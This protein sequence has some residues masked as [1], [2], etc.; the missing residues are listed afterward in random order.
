LAYSGWRHSV[1]RFDA[2]N[3]AAGGKGPGL[4]RAIVVVALALVGCGAAP[5]RPPAVAADRPASP[6]NRAQLVPAA[7][8]AATGAANAPPL[9]MAEPALPDPART[10]LFASGSADLSTDAQAKIRALAASLLDDGRRH[11]LL[12]GHT[13]DLGSKAYCLALAAKR[14]MAVSD[15]LLALGV[16]ANQIRRRNRGCEIGGD[17][18]CRSEACRHSRRRVDIAVTRR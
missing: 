13:E 14:T 1:L 5:Q 17:R 7:S 6:E 15:A 2:R 12:T 16:R 4:G 18:A 11:V 8:L 9:D 3:R 10:I